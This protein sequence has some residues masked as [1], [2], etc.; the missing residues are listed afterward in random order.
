MPAPKPKITNTQIFTLQLF[1]KD[2][3]VVEIAR[4]R[5]ITAG[6]VNKHLADLIETGETVDLDRLIER[7]AQTEIQEAIATVGQESLSKIRTHLQDKYTYDAIRLVR[8][9]CRYE[10]EQEKS[11]QQTT[12]DSH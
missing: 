7:D 10:Q 1:Q 4:E 2:Y 11:T 12:A 5:K 3:S 8:S 9:K 6:T